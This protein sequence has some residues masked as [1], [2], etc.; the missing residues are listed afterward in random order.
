MEAAALGRALEDEF[1]WVCSLIVVP[2]RFYLQLSLLFFPGSLQP[3][4][5]T[6]ILQLAARC[7]T[8]SLAL[9]CL[10][11]QIHALP[12]TKPSF[13]SQV[14]KAPHGLA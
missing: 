8:F 1:F 4:K 9:T 11:Q 12:R 2:S 13:H 3:E 5:C 7:F 10:L 6:T 14:S